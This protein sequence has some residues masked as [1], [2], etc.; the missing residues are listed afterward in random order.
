[1]PSREETVEEEKGSE[2]VEGKR[3][4][5]SVS[6]HF[7]R[8]FEL[9]GAAS[10]PK[11]GEAARSGTAP[12]LSLL[13]SSHANWCGISQAGVPLREGCCSVRRR[14]ELPNQRFALGRKTIPSQSSRLQTQTM[15]SY[16]A[17]WAAMADQQ[18]GE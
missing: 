12:R 15:A 6:I 17:R 14:D 2:T 11:T 8:F 7:S 18:D 16:R 10:W 4:A 5:G 1:M 3:N 13:T 9:P